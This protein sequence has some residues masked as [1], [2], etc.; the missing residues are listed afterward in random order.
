MR[1]YRGK[2]ID[3]KGW[4][5][6]YYF[7]LE[8]KPMDNEDP[9]YNARV[10]HGIFDN[11]ELSNPVDFE[12]T[13][14]RASYV[15]VHQASV[16]QGIGINAVG[17]KTEVHGGDICK[18]DITQ[19]HTDEKIYRTG[20]IKW[21]DGGFVLHEIGGT[22]YTYLKPEMEL[23]IIGNTTDNPELLEAGE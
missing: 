22:G 9:G 1:Q 8:N 21:Q 12:G 20:V 13:I 19:L 11:N 15:E 5:Y 17:G 3:G 6:G 2:R 4:V 10:I 16:G 7:C 14:H 23:E 18:D